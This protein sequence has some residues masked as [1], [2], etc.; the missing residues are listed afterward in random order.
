MTSRLQLKICGI[1]SMGDA[2]AAAG[3]GADYLGFILYPESPRYVPVAKYRR[4]RPDLPPVKRVAV[5]VEPS[6]ADLNA[7]LG[8]GFDFFQ[9][10]FRPDVSMVS[11]S[12]WTEV[13]TPARLWL[14]PKLAGYADVSPLLLPMAGTFLFD[15]YHPQKF[16]GT[17]ETGDWLKFR[18][19]QSLYPRK[20]WILSGGLNPANIAEAIQTSSARFLDVNSGVELSPGVKDPT[21]LRALAA[22]LRGLAPVL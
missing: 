2:Q 5:L 9:I 6:L 22:A 15:T 12:E 3:V 14:A 18:R 1:T 20:T 13:V 10:H 8:V 17:G 4:L 7:A 11:L 21:K 19:H 16:G